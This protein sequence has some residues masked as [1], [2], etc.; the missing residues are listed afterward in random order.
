MTEELEKKGCTVVNASGDADV[1]IVKAAVKASEHLICSLEYYMAKTCI[2]HQY[3]W[4]MTAAIL[5][6][7]PFLESNIG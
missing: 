1:D 4:V 7:G 5:K 2:R 3:S 6:M